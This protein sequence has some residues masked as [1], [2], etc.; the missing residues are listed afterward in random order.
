[1]RRAR[2]Y[3]DNAKAALA[4]L[5]SSDIRQALSDIADFCVERAY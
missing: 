3:A 5:P 2:A 4:S 1:M